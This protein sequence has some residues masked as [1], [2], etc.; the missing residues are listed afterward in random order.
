MVDNPFF[1]LFL[2]LVRTSYNS[3]LLLLGFLVKRLVPRCL[4]ASAVQNHR[5]SLCAHSQYHSIST[6]EVPTPLAHSRCDAIEFSA[7]SQRAWIPLLELREI[8]RKVIK[9]GMN[10]Y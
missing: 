1:V 2:P 8:F 7:D 4:V 3:I 5:L 6:T 10:E 9:N